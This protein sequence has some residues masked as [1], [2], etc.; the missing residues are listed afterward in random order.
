DPL[1]PEAKLIIAGGPL[2]GTL[3]PSFGRV[4]VGGKSPLTLGIKEANSGGPAAQKLDRLGFRAVVVEGAPADNG[5]YVLYVSK[6]GTSLEKA[7]DLTGMKT[8]ALAEKLGQKNPQAAIISIG[9]AGERK[10]KG[11]SVAFTDKD[12]YS[13]RHAGRGGLGAVMG[14][15]GLKAIVV[16]DKSAPRIEL[17]DREAFQAAMKAWPD[18]LKSDPQVQNMSRFGTTSGLVPLRTIG[19]APSKNYTGEPTEGFEK[20]GGDVIEKTNKERGG[21]MD[22]C[23]PGCLVRCAIVYN[24]AQGNHLTSALEYETMALMGTNLGFAD[25][26]AIAEFDRWCDEMGFDT[27][28]MGSALGVAASAGKMRMGDADSVR[29]LFKEIE[30][31]TEF[32]AVL[33]NGVVSVCKHLGI[34]RVPA[35]KGQAIPAHDPR[36][37]KATGVTYHTSPMGADHTAGSTYEKARSST[38]Q[39]ERSLKA[40]ISSAV[41]DA[42]GYCS[43]AQP[44]DKKALT[45]FTLALLNARYGTNIEAADLLE[46]GRQTL[47]DELKFNE[48]TE[49]GTAHGPDPEF[50]RTEP[51]PPSDTVFDIDPEEIKSIWDQLD[52]IELN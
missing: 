21:R 41:N 17:A 22:G 31:G 43:L 51:L 20:L 10:Y 32:G 30:E 18:T 12:G 48:G 46:I 9:P 24:D 7:G 19:S 1:G 11:A 25:P 29:A 38:G 45:S 23:M 49:F 14:A 37:S 40:Q 28:E 6:D 15:K 4:S 36:F 42:I 34:S 52:T 5:L 33:G 44:D 26:D 3:A 39:V 16:D 8:Y 50:V 47:R 13:S 35:F 27:I 2:A